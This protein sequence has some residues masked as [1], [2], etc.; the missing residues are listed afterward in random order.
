MLGRVL[1]DSFGTLIFILTI[2]LSGGNSIIIGT[3][4]ATIIFLIGGISGAYVNPAVAFAEYMFGSLQ[5]HEF[6]AY[7]LGHL[8]AAIVAVKLY[9]LSKE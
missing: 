8:I 4:L 1:I 6:L 3:V 2:F 9:T 7:S 5:L